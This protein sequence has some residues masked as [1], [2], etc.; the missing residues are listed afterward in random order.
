MYFKSL[1]VSEKV[2]IPVPFEGTK[3]RKVIIH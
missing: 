1:G 3:T 2:I